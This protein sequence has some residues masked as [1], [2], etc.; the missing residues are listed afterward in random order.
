MNQLLLI[1]FTSILSLFFNSPSLSIRAEKVD[2]GWTKLDAGAFSLSAPSGW[3]FHKMQGV[4]SYVGK[5]S[6]DGIVLKFDYGMYSDDLRDTV[7]PRYVTTEQQVGSHKSK[8]VY[9]RAPGHGITAIYF[10]SA[11]GSDKLCLWGQDFTQPQQELALEIFRT[12]RFPQ[13]SHKP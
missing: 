10:P 6:G 8:I 2:D 13:P 4:D 5:F 7:A 11:A 3:E 12:I 9:P 1:V